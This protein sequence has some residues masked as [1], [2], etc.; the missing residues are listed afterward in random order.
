M[1]EQQT[2]PSQAASQRAQMIVSERPWG[3]FHQFATNQNVTVKTIIV[4]PGKRLSL[5]RHEHREELWHV[6]DGV[7]D[8]HVDGVERSVAAGEEVLVPQGAVHRLGNSGTERLHVLEIAF[9]HFDED[10]I[11]RLQDDFDR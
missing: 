4:E 1:S 2:A 8:T 7:A 10:D 3:R 11:E 9:G 6:L 5:Q